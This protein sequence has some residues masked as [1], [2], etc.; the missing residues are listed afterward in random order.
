[1]D[2]DPKS[3]RIASGLLAQFPYSSALEW[4]E[5]NGTGGW[6]SSTVSGAHSRRHHGL[7]VTAET[8]DADPFVVCSKLEESIIESNTRF[9]LGCNQYP[10]VI[11]PAGHQHL[12]GF[13]RNLFP[14]FTY[15]VAGL[16]IR[17]TIA[18]LH[19]E[20]TVVILYEFGSFA[21]PFTLELRPMYSARSVQ[22]LSVAN[23]F[24][25]RQY[26]FSNG[27]L[28]LKNYS[29]TPE[30]FIS[31]PGSTFREDQHWY[32]NLIYVSELTRGA[33]HT[34]DLYSHGV[35]CVRLKGGDKLGVIVSTIEPQARRNA[36]ALFQKEERR[37]KKLTNDAETEKVKLLTL[38]ADQFV[39]SDR[40]NKP[41][42][43]AGYY[44]TESTRQD[45]LVSV[46][47]LFLPTARH[48]VA[49]RILQELAASLGKVGPGGNATSWTV[50][51]ILW[52]YLA[53]YQYYLF[54]RDAAFVR[55]LLP[56][57]TSIVEYLVKGSLSIGHVD[58]DGMLVTMISESADGVPVR[59]MPVNA[60]WYNAVRILEFL[61]TEA[62]RG[63]DPSRYSARAE[64]VMENFI[65]VF[66][67]EEDGCLYNYFIGSTA[68]REI[69][70]HQLYA[71][72]LPYPLLSKHRA[73]RVLHVIERDLVTPRG[74]R[75][76]NPGDPNYAPT[77]C[78]TG[79]PANLGT[80]AM[81]WIGAY[82]DALILLRGSRGRSEAHSILEMVLEDLDRGCVG[83][84]S[85]YFDGD[86][87]HTP[88]GS[89]ASARSVAEVLRVVTEHNLLHERAGDKD[90]LAS[91]PFRR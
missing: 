40:E 27:V 11:Y 55:T 25:N 61:L 89:V 58:E 86:A 62:G 72:V 41:V 10:G 63:K 43:K 9:D 60:L 88:R 90:V 70:P 85:E 71:I 52:Y 80:V 47:G 91:L 66:W 30:I 32:Y 2:A 64:K 77:G 50:E 28:R 46:P 6:S 76:L 1:M 3:N 7:L 18:A 29:S 20:P 4:L 42:V 15:Q 53:V 51:E 48:K 81:H 82:V 33:D 34:E 73:D 44:V 36:F 16:T 12:I 68:N 14:V 35:F 23:E 31:V 22:N 67:N 69:R 75:S 37:R 54:T 19:G 17:K 26:V 5:T 49:R 65:R 79:T 13:E 57:L 24:I 45:V 8:P 78:D 56:M 87:P 84:L 38:A 21:R 83:T 39:I 59:S 74:L